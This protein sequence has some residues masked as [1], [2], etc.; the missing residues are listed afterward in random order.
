MVSITNPEYWENHYQEGTTRW[1]LGQAAPPF[2][3]LL[4][5]A[6]A[7]P[8]GKVAVLGCGRGYSTLR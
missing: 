6:Y 3:S 7:P 4:N 1:D 8:P 2:V 5:S